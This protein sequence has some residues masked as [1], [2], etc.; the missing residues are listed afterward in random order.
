VSTPETALRLLGNLGVEDRRWILER[1][2]LAARAR[3]AEH[4]DEMRDVEP[5]REPPSFDLPVND[6]FEWDRSVARLSGANR[7][8]LVQALQS[9][10]AWIV[11][12]VLRAASWPWA[13]EVRKSLPA[14][15]RADLATMARG[16]VHLGRPAV[17]VLVR[18]LAARAQ[19][20][21]AP[22]PELTGLRALVSRF[23]RSSRR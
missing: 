8:S 17:C 22:L 6:D 9:E 5:S 1:L 10:P 19:S 7:N 16:D 13:D 14:S 23:R 4:V 20:W 21:P 15:M 12:A 3:L 11:D 18:E 2:P